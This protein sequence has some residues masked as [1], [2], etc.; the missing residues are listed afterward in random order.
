MTKF[1][2]KIN[3][4]KKIIEKAVNKYKNI[5][6]ACSFGKDSMVIVHLAKEVMP[7]IPV[8]YIATI[9][10]PPETLK[11]AVKMNQEMNLNIK[12]Y[13]VAKEVPLIFK[14]SGIEV[15]L[16]PVQEFEKTSKKSKEDHKKPLYVTDPDFCCQLLKVEPTKVAVK[17]L[18]AWITGLRKTEGWTRAN[19]QEIE[20]KNNLVKINPILEW[21]ELDVWRYLNSNQIAPNPLYAKGYR[22]LGCAV[23]T[24]ITSD[25]Q[26]ERAGRWQ[27]TSKC[28]G[29]CG[30]HTKQLK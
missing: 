16:L 30:I 11:Y 7:K 21:T 28:G 26:H 22:S 8:F 2:D 5:A 23:C 14:N 6:V 13:L 10:K 12:V 17:N 15:I 9:Y 19:Y 20:I 25:D 3:H 24:K 1:L 29:E 18:D 4:S 27:S